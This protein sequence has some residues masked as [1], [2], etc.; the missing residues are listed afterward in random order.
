VIIPAIQWHL[1]CFALPG[2]EGLVFTSPAGKPLHHPA[3]LARFTDWVTTL[4]P[5]PLPRTVIPVPGEYFLDY[6]ARLA[7]A[8]HLE[9]GELTGA[10]DD[11]AA[12]TLHG[13]A[14]GHSM[15]RSGLRPPQASRWPGSPGCIGP[16]PATICATRR[17]SGRRCARPAAAAPPATASPSRSPATCRRI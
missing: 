8:N 15:S 16:T 9:F 12:I 7:Q 4:P 14:A 2:D 17:D 1:S 5:R 3:R 11:T 13:P 10:L 6:I